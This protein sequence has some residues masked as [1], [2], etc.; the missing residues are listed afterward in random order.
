V[1]TEVTSVAMV[2]PVTSMPLTPPLKRVWRRINKAKDSPSSR[3]D[4]S[5]GAPSLDTF[6]GGRKYD[7]TVPGVRCSREVTARP[8]FPRPQARHV[9]KLLK[10]P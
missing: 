1:V 2:M 10:R 9:L 3:A 6:G 7:L 5:P 8:P 4:D